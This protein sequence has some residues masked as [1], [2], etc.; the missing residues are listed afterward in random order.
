MK[1]ERRRSSKLSLEVRGFMNSL[2][3]FLIVSFYFEANGDLPL[4]C[5]KIIWLRIIVNS[6]LMYRRVGIT[7]RSFI[8]WDYVVEF[9][10]GI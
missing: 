9:Y 6:L 8:R 4:K 7:E 3:T 2:L 1:K 5:Q 10:M